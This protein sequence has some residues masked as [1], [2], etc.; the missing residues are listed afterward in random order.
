MLSEGTYLDGNDRRRKES[1]TAR[2]QPSVL[3]RTSRAQA[4]AKRPLGTP[5]ARALSGAL[6]G[7]AGT[8][9]GQ[10]PGAAAAQPTQA[11]PPGVQFLRAGQAS[12]GARDVCRLL[13]TLALAD[14]QAGAAAD[15]TGD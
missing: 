13:R 3:S 12:Q 9:P 6:Q 2:V 11:A 7:L 5:L 4:G 14:A 1:K 10:N 15:C 8:L